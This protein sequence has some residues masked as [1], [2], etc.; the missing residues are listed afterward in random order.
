LKAG[1]TLEVQTEGEMLIA[2]K[3][4]EGNPFERWRG[5]GHLPVGTTGD[6]YLRYTRDGDRG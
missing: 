5:R 1:Q 2:W 6:D 3:R 4:S